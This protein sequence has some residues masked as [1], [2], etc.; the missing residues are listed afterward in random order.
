MNNINEIT[1]SKQ[2]S[3]DFVGRADFKITWQAVEDSRSAEIW[4][5]SQDQS[6]SEHFR[7]FAGAEETTVEF[8][9]A[10]IG[11]FISVWLKNTSDETM[12]LYLS[13]PVD[14]DTVFDGIIAEW[15]VGHIQPEPY[16]IIDNQ[17]PENSYSNISS[18]EWE[19]VFPFLCLRSLPL[20][21][22]NLNLNLNRYIQINNPK[23]IT[24]YKDLTATPDILESFS[25]AQKI[26]TT[27]IS[28]SEFI[29]SFDA[30]DF[31]FSTLPKFQPALTS[32][33]EDYTE[34]DVADLL[35]KVTGKKLELK[36]IVH[37][38]DS[39]KFLNSCWSSAIGLLLTENKKDEYQCLLLDYIA[40]LRAFYFL[41]KIYYNHVK[42]EDVLEL[43]H[44]FDN[45]ALTD[46]GE[47]DDEIVDEKIIDENI[48]DNL[49]EPSWLLLLN[50]TIIVPDSVI[51]VNNL[52]SD[53]Q[54]TSNSG[55]CRFAGI[56]DVRTVYQKSKSYALGD[57]AKITNLVAGE[58]KNY[59]YESLESNHDE[60]TYEKECLDDQ[61][62]ESISHLI[63]EL[64]NEVKNVIANDEQ[65]LNA[66]GLTPSYDNLGLVINGVSDTVWT[67]TMSDALLAQQYARNITDRASDSVK[68]KV[69]DL[70]LSRHYTEIRRRTN[71]EINNSENSKPVNA[72]Y[73]WVDLIHHFEMKPRGR[74]LIMEFMVSEPA[75]NF[76]QSLLD[77][78]DIPIIQPNDDSLFSDATNYTKI[79]P[80]NYMTYQ[81]K[82]DA[83][84]MPKPPAETIQI[85]LEK[86][87]REGSVISGCL[88]V[89]SGYKVKT[90]SKLNI[91]VSD[92]SKLFTGYVGETDNISHSKTPSTQNVNA[93]AHQQQM[94][95]SANSTNKNE[96]ST[97]SLSQGGSKN[98]PFLPIPTPTPIK[99]PD[100]IP[101]IYSDTF[102][103]GDNEDINFAFVCHAIQ[104]SID[105]SIVCE[106]DTSST[107]NY[108]QLLDAWQ[109]DVFR[110]LQTAYQQQVIEY[111]HQYNQR[112]LK[113]SR[114]RT[115]IVER[116]SLTTEA[117]EILT[118]GLGDSSPETLRFLQRSFLWGEMAYQFFPWESGEKPNN[119]QWYGQ[120]TSPQNNDSLFEA[121]LN[122]GSA[123]VLI[124][125]N[126]RVITE[127]LFTILFN[128]VW[129]GLPGN[130]ITSTQGAMI[131]QEV[132][133][134]LDGLD[135]M[136]E[137]GVDL[138]WTKRIPTAHTYLQE[139]SELPTFNEKFY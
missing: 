15:K 132:S 18:D 75:T 104:Y 63:T 101:A 43:M 92:E 99:V 131:L 9:N 45:D 105:I 27:Y 126:P 23:K 20:N 134:P 119:Q 41:S 70:R 108:P 34:S 22:I 2:G 139:N 117:L 52:V 86:S 42:V 120:Q 110:R 78:N 49:T 95:S 7:Q 51:P 57:V 82:F 127:A 10:G 124:P 79:T 107:S 35:F 64:N 54:Q 103:V 68:N 71:T 17:D 122:A 100:P 48:V 67:E 94:D 31:P 89:P 66:T 74:A 61:S 125:I 115:R 1:Y 93:L 97:V 73:R 6:A 38:E 33:A 25:K 60:K 28:S 90:G 96:I 3:K 65:D 76:C 80:T 53:T 13:Y 14:S 113:A 26:I 114:G 87:N 50:A 106:A 46:S 138:C 5:I 88:K 32:L 137:H 16:P 135:N 136:H 77:Y 36:S 24:L 116:N 69:A 81:A 72:I 133:K 121:F 19:A 85:S 130:S 91:V 128:Q 21:D 39:V 29:G 40:S 112:L 109:Q 111:N 11:S 4:L 102:V 47:S 129:D 83:P 123:R 30:L 56:G 84:E 59:S 37:G 98:A 44:E 118:A 8:F 55:W 12:E 62:S 58:K